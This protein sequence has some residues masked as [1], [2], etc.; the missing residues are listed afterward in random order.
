[1]HFDP[2][3]QLKSGYVIL[4]KLS[5]QKFEEIYGTIEKISL[6]YFND[7]NGKVKPSSHTLGLSYLLQTRT[8]KRYIWNWLKQIPALP[9]S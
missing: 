8:W 1:M 5:E 4:T 3:L 9:P 6:K 7:I 2:H